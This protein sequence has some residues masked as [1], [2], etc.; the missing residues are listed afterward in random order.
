MRQRHTAEASMNQGSVSRITIWKN[1]TT[2]SDL[3]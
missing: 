3:T 2:V 1:L